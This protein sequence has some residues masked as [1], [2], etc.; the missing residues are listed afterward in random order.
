MN[1]A[2]PFFSSS[3][4]RIALFGLCFAGACLAQNTNS[5]DIR[6]IVTDPTGA[7]VPGAAVTLLDLDTGVARQ[8]T[9]NAAGLYDAVSILPGR[10]RITFE[11]SGFQKVVRDGIV[12]SVGAISVD[13]QLPVGAAQQQVVV[14]EEAP[15]LKTETAEQSSTAA[16]STLQEMPNVTP[17]WQ[18]YVKMIPGATGAP[19]TG[20]GSGGVQ[21]PGVSMAINGTL[22]FYS[23]YLADGASIRLPHSANIGDDQIFESISEVQIITSTFS[24]QY[25]GGGDVFNVISKSGANQWHGAAYEYFQNDDLNARSFFDVTKPRQRYND[26]GGAFSGPIVKDKVFFYYA[27]DHIPNPSQTTITTTMPTA[28]MQQG[29]FDQTAFGTIY[30]PATGQPFP[31]NSIPQSRFDPVAAKIQSYYLAPNLPG[32]TNNYRVLVTNSASNMREFGRLDYNTSSKNRI[33]FSI[34]EHGS[35]SKSGGTICPINCQHSTG[36]GYDAQISDLYSFSPTVINEFR[37]GFVRQGNWFTPG[38]E[39]LNYPQKLGW[40]FAAANVFPNINI[41]GT[42][43]NTSL[44]PADSAVSAIYI[45]NSWDPSDVLTMIR[46]KH[47]LHFGGEVLME[48]DNSTPWGNL[49]P[50]AFTFNGQ[51]TSSTVGYADFLLGDAQAWSALVQGEAGMRS[52]N[53]SLFAQDDIKLLPNFTLNVGLRWEGH[54]GFSEVHNQ[55]GTF[56]PTLTNPLTNTPGAILFGVNAHRNLIFN[57]VYNLFLPR[58]GF[59]WSPRS[60]W[61]VR[62]GF[63]IY[64]SLW[65]MDVDGSPLGFGTATGGSTSANPGQAPVVTLS[66][67]GSNLPV[68]RANT[69]PGGYNGQGGGNIP[70]MPYNLPVGKVYQ[71]T[72]SVERQF[73]GGIVVEAAYVGSH[74]TGLEF[75][76]DI[77]QL[78]ASKLGQGQSARPFPQYLGIGPSV[79]GGLT[80]RFDNYSNYDALQLLFT[81][82]FSHGLSAQFSY[83]WS[84]MLDEQDTSGWGSH[85]GNGVYQD[86]FN[87][88]ANYALSNFD[89]PQA[90]KGFLVYQA[91][92][93]TGHQY[94][95]SGIGD[96]ILG[97]WQIS[98][99]FI[100]QSGNPFTVT[101]NSNVGSGALDGSWYPNITGNPVPSNQTINQWFNQLAY[102]TP[103]T[104]TFGNNGRNT[105][106]GP[107]LVTVNLSLAKTFRIPRWE[108]AGLQIRLDAN[109][110]LNHPCFSPPNASLSAASLASGVPNPAIGQI[111]TVTV[112][113]RFM[114]LGARFSF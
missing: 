84:K 58:V 82:R 64:T 73:S 86:A 33:T 48:Q 76:E 15:L 63:G 66:G 102:A 21:N 39:G 105:L 12:L 74:A 23:S 75:Q 108:R 59:A 113:G 52:K 103:A 78:P 45:E 62:G 60:Q 41:T 10:Y 1:S 37:W 109:N 43:G 16:F 65:S 22:P 19:A 100:A 98:P 17:D 55:W 77:N 28:A 91:P 4:R 54:G 89:V 90:F 112:N 101:M 110:I 49:N 7:V 71:W 11:K 56:D 38:S 99:Q 92:R 8:L 57:S 106:R 85:Y 34:T 107:D 81:K 70:Y 46:G 104:N 79:P 29:I 61:A 18:N 51:F 96:A 30:D 44:N 14:T 27:L 83:V 53:P 2:R 95:K 3:L 32:I 87:P 24:A 6:G 26:Y 42:G 13:A 69:N 94:L 93:G 68:V 50:G 20:Q 72:T 40:N 35:T 111:T 47:I 114:Q 88:A 97:G 67:S 31:N 9:T 80:G 36:E 5:G 25:G